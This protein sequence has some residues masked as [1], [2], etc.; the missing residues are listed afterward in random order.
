MRYFVLRQIACPRSTTAKQ[1]LQGAVSLLQLTLVLLNKRQQVLRAI[2][3]VVVGQS[4]NAGLHGFSD[5]D[6][7]WRDDGCFF[8]SHFGGHMSVDQWAVLA[9]A[10][11]L[12]RIKS[13]IIWELRQQIEQ[14]RRG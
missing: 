14:V 13:V 2:H 8:G 10:Q 6:G 5:P 7:D 12:E 1:W 9:V 3:A 11:M 4:I